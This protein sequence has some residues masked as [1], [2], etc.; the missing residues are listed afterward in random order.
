M[1][2]HNTR[3]TVHVFGVSKGSLTRLSILSLTS[4]AENIS[5]NFYKITFSLVSESNRVRLIGN[6]TCNHQ[7]LQ[8]T[9]N[10]NSPPTWTRTR[11]T[12]AVNQLLLPT[13]LSRKMFDLVELREI[14]S[15]SSQCKCDIIP[16]YYS[17]TKYL[18]SVDGI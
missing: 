11:D 15:R 9:Q 4:Q 7:H 18:V 13:E 10:N 2:L 12:L 17:P 6:Q 8:G 16:L 1:I 5:I 3:D 14:E